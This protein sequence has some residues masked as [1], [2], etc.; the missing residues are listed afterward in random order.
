MAAPLISLEA[1][2]CTAASRAGRTGQ[3]LMVPP[4]GGGAGAAGSF[5]TPRTAKMGCAHRDTPSRHGTLTA[6]E[7]A[8]LER[9]AS[10]RG[11]VVLV[12]PKVH[13][14]ANWRRTQKKLKVLSRNHGNLES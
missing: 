9:G 3:Q 10:Q 5:R 2:A 12:A 14:L 11:S 4:D 8:V 1:I 13:N 6:C 7:R